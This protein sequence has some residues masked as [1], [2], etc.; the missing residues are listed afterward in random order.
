MLEIFSFRSIEI[1][2]D[3]SRSKECIKRFCEFLVK[4]AMKM[5]NLKKKKMKFLT[6]E[7]QE[8][9][10]NA[11]ICYIFLKKIENK[12]LKDKNV[13]VITQK[14]IEDQR[15]AYAIQN[16]KYLKKFL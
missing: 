1:K 12:Y 9:Y 15:I 14:N 13:I 3:V 6:K 7:Q 10:E 8:S 5:I 2:H 4:H 16:K 11:E